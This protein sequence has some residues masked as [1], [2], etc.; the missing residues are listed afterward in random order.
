MKHD[1]PMTKPASQAKPAARPQTQAQSRPAARPTVV[2]KPAGAGM[3]GKPST[4]K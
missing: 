1:K 2:V 3:G 4:H